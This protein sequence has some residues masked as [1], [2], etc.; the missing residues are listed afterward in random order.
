VNNSRIIVSLDYADMAPAL[1]LVEKLDPDRCRLKV[2]K[3][4]FT[5]HGPLIIDKFIQAGFPVF[6]DLK[7]HDIPNTVA[8]ACNAAA[9]LGVWMVNVHASGGRRMLEGAREA[10]DKFENK[11]LLI[12]VTVLTSMSSDDLAEI[13]IHSTVDEQVMRLA[14]LVR[15]SG[16]DG[17]VCSAQEA[18]SLKV[19]FKDSLC[20]VTPGIRP[21]GSAA[22]DQRRIVTPYDA[23]LAG[24]DYL[25]IGRPITQAPNP[26]SVLEQISKDVDEALQK[27]DQQGG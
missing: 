20:L 11:P 18:H 12:A 16:I 19:A 24:S 6:L 27:R 22:D 13:G 3:E 25:V 10:I 7:F 1:A 4:L 5:R 2:G 15:Q 14:H 26:L 8:G 17:I 9:S 23:I 21:A